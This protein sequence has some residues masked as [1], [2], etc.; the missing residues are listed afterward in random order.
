MG[1]KSLGSKAVNRN[2]RFR[3]IKMKMEKVFDKNDCIPSTMT[4]SEIIC[5]KCGF[6][7][8]YK[9]LRCPECNSE[10]K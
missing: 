1:R 8:R 2:Q 3:L 9:F 4:T 6:R 10:Q 5:H 7:A